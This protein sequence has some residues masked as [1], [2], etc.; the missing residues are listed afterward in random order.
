MIGSKEISFALTLEEEGSGLRRDRS[1]PSA[2]GVNL[3]ELR[4]FRKVPLLQSDLSELSSRE[5]REIYEEIWSRSGFDFVPTGLDYFLFDSC[6]VCGAGTTYRW[7]ELSLIGNNSGNANEKI[8][9]LVSD[10]QLERASL[11]I[12]QLTFSRRRR[13]KTE[14]GW[15]RY[16]QQ[17]T[18]RLNRVQHR[19]LKMVGRSV[20]PKE[21][22]AQYASR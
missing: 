10:L 15:L 17:W 3:E 11:L 12:S 13:H 2:F 5:A 4:R 8:M 6:V 21:E 19:A 18:N 9:G 14:P 22:S 1:P 16:S 7:L 20:Q